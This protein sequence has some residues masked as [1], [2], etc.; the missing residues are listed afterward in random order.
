MTVVFGTLGFTPEKL[1]P[2]VRNAD[3]V[4][5]LVFFHDHEPRS[6]AA[7]EKVRAFCRDRGLEVEGAEIDAFDIVE[8]AQAI[9]RRLGREP[10]EEIVFNITGGTA[11]LSAAATLV[12]ILEGVRTVYVDERTWE[13]F[14]LPLLAVGPHD[15]LSPEQRKVLAFIAKRKEGCR[16][17][18]ILRGLKLSRGTVSYH[19]QTLKRKRLVSASPADGRGEILKALPSSV[20]LLER[21]A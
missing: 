3:A 6:R 12:C 16:Q 2:T 10:R 14:P 13:E 7:A 1:L 18:D 17:A 20:L 5:K 19:V 11:V 8:S 4:R 9:R 15:L 21:A